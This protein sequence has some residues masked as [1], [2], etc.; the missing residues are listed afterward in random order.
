MKLN[1]SL[2][3][4][5]I[6]LLSDIAKSQGTALEPSC[7]MPVTVRLNCKSEFSL[8]VMAA[9]IEVYRLAAQTTE[10]RQAILDL[11][12]QPFFEYVEG[13]AGGGCND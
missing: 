5:L 4:Q 6:E 3:T 9:V 8:G 7:L 11:G 10:G 2:S 13:P 1:S 12:L